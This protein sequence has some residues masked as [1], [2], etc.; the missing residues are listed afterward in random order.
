MGLV[1]GI[2]VRVQ[3]VR[4]KELVWHLAQLKDVHNVYFLNKILQLYYTI[5][6]PKHNH[7][8]VDQ[9]FCSKSETIG[10]WKTHTYCNFLFKDT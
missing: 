9:V 3:I 7:D 1:R 6:A 5:I 10:A 4:C 8:K 2:G